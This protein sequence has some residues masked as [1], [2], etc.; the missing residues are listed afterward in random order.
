MSLLNALCTNISTATN[1]PFVAVHQKDIGGGCI[2]KA[3]VVEGHDGRRYFVKFNGTSDLSMFEGEFEGLQELARAKALRVPLP[4]CHGDADGQ[5][6]LVLEYVELSRVSSATEQQLGQRL[7]A[8]HQTVRARFG[9][10]RNNTIGSTR[11]LND[12]HSD[13]IEFYREQR[14]RVQLDLA[15]KRGHFK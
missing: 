2:N 12:W 1:A 3:I 10:H 5:A 9:W 6:F 13:W 8:Q 14:L 7:A 11:Q 4:I 15:A